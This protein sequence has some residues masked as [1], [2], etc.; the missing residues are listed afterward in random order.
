MTLKIH[1]QEAGGGIDI[2]FVIKLLFVCV[3]FAKF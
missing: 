2:L 3:R 1:C